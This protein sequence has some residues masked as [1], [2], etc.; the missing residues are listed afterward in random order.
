MKL[1][2]ESEREIKAI[3]GDPKQVIR[4]GTYIT[5][6]L[7]KDTKIFCTNNDMKVASLIRVLWIWY[8]NLS[9]EERRKIYENT[10]AYDDLVNMGMPRH[11]KG[12]ATAPIKIMFLAKDISFINKILHEWRLAERRPISFKMITFKLLYWIQNIGNSIKVRQ[13]KIKAFK[14]NYYDKDELLKYTKEDKVKIIKN[15]KMLKA[16]NACVAKLSTR[17]YVK[18][19][20]LAEYQESKAHKAKSERQKKEELNSLLP[21][22]TQE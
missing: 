8:A 13:D 17:E 3:I 7:N 18:K 5:P 10:P 21:N 2:K 20:D 11:H 22:P 12:E 9:H 19:S 16:H 1:T 6:H 14:T 4:T 15:L